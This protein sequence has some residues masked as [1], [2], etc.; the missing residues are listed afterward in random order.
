MP[1]QRLETL[2]PAFHDKGRLRVGVD[3]DIAV[4]DP[5]TV[6]SSIFPGKPARAP[7]RQ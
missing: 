7:L 1:A 5:A 2:A 6:A 4:F 3:A